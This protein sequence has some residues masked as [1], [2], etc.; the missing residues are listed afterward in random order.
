[1]APV[2]Q[3]IE[4]INLATPIELVQIEKSGVS[5]IV[6]KELAR[7]LQISP[8]RF[9]EILGGT[10]GKVKQQAWGKQMVG[11]GLG[12]AAIGIIRLLGAVGTILANSTH[13]SAKKFDAGKWLGQ[14]IE[15]AH[16]SLGG[17]KP[18]DLIRSPSGVKIVARLLG[19]IESGAYQ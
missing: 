1:M 7:K 19:A 16:P 2:D 4:Q 17:S 12:F 10:K 3:L 14:W 11:G 8:S 15:Q 18:A 5:G 13:P 6:I 9:Q